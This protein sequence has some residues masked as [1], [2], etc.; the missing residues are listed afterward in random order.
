MAECPDQIA[1][2][3]ATADE[4]GASIE[5][6]AAIPIAAQKREEPPT[7]KA[8]RGSQE[9]PTHEPAEQGIPFLEVKQCQHKGSRGDG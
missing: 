7:E 5:A 8:G 4:N 3:L 9:E 6:A 1:R 2:R